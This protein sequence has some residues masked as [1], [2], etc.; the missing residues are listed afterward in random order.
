M[1]GDIPVGR[2]FDQPTTAVEQQEKVEA[3]VSGRIQE[4]KN[5]LQEWRNRCL[6]AEQTRDAH[7]HSWR[8]AVAR[9]QDW[10]RRNRELN[11]S[12]CKLSE[13]VDELTAQR[14]EAQ[15]D[16]ADAFN[17]ME[18]LKQDLGGQETLIHEL[19][20]EVARLDGKLLDA[21]SESE[22]WKHQLAN[23]ADTIQKLTRRA[24]A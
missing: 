24:E 5:L 19:Q 1:L 6:E 3:I 23:Q 21:R 15:R 17:Q 14:D 18:K 4:L 22:A 11:E 2:V 20:Q 7:Y 16:R 12:A 9:E 10:K 13:R 8:N